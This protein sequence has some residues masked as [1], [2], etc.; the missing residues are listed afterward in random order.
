MLKAAAKHSVSD[1]IFATPPVAPK[2]KRQRKRAP[3]PQE[4]IADLSIKH[5]EVLALVQE[6]TQLALEELE[7]G[8]TLSAAKR[9]SIVRQA[10]VAVYKEY[11]DDPEV[12]AAVQA[13]I[14]EYHNDKKAEKEAE[15]A[16]SANSLV[17]EQAS[18]TRT[19]GQYT[20]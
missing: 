18:V 16:H 12:M 11:K 5:D 13:K 10:M 14:D 20:M 8:E 6:L 17:D 3:Q 2:K 19:P 9:L 15:K 4:A 1:G 7:E